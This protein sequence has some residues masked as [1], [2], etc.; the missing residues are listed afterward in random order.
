MDH[1]ADKW[2]EL[3]VCEMAD[4]WVRSMN[5]TDN[6]RRRA[7]ADAGFD[8]SMAHAEE[9][10]EKIR[11]RIDAGKTITNERTMHP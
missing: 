1:P 9:A 3:A 8:R 4:H 5:H 7:E 6:P 10:R 2:F 11:K